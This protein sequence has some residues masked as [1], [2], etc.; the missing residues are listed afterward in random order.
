M[1]VRVVGDSS[2]H[3]PEM[4]T[5]GPNGDTSRYLDPTVIGSHVLVRLHQEN[6]DE[7]KQARFKV[8]WGEENL[9]VDAGLSYL[10][11]NFTLQNS[12]S[13]ANNFWQAYAGYG[14]PS[15]RT[16]GVLVPTAIYAGRSRPRDSSPGLRA[17]ARCRLSCWCT[18]LTICTATS[19]VW[20]IRRPSR[21]PGSTTGAAITRARWTLQL[22]PG[23]V[24]DITEKTWRF[25]EHA[26]RRRESVASPST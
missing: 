25:P 15:G 24:Q 12:N 4:S 14:A 22:D 13:F 23:S 18:P 11:D 19:R 10:E 16:S 26:F 21:F 6:S 3:L 20:A 1:G 9:K 8:T 17:P 2:S 7:I 5:Y